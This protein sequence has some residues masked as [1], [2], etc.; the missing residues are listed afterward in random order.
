MSEL[1]N[2]LS[3]IADIR[4]K[5]AASTWFRGFAPEL[6]MVIGVLVLVVA[7]AQA[8]LPEVLY[9][10]V[11]GYIAVWA[12]VLVVTSG[13]VTVEAVIRSRRLHGGMAPAML[14]SALHRALPFAAAGVVITAVVCAF[15]PGSMLLLPGLWLILIG[16]LGFAAL[17]NLPG[18]ICWAAA[19]YLFCGSAVLVLTGWTGELSPWMMGLPIAVGQFGVAII[20]NRYGGEESDGTRA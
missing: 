17:G 2:A 7:L 13:V 14:R 6:N 10:G 9:L 19:W 4:A 18:A 12:T 20:L 11:S 16:L 15:F 5:L 8:L 1:D 3:Q